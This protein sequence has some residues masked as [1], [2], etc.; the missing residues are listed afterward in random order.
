MLFDPRPQGP[1]ATRVSS[2]GSQ[3]Q[4]GAA[5]TLPRAPC[6]LGA[7]SQGGGMR[8]IDL[9]LAFLLC[10]A[11]AAAPAAYAADS[12]APAVEITAEPSHHLALE[13]EWVRAFLVEVPPHASTRLHHHGHDNV[14][15]ALVTL[16]FP[17]HGEVAPGSGEQGNRGTGATLSGNRCHPFRHRRSS[18]SPSSPSSPTLTTRLRA[19]PRLISW[20]TGPNSPRINV[21]VGLRSASNTPT[22][23]TSASRSAAKRQT[24][25]DHRVRL[26][27]RRPTRRQTSTP[28][29]SSQPG[30]PRCGLRP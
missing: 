10:L 6:Y 29:G 4:S 19:V 17:K 21:R 3:R 22:G 28:V 27:S 7:L 12:A 14:F 5:W 25:R 13:N 30:R 2:K 16:E 15:V 24:S 11:L 18:I 1:R 23:H 20:L 26:A 9:S 8:T